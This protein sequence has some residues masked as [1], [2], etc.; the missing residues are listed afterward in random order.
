MAVGK[1]QQILMK[2]SHITFGTN[3]ASSSRAAAAAS[4]WRSRRPH[5]HSS[6]RGTGPTPPGNRGYRHRQ[7]ESLPPAHARP[8]N[9]S[10]AAQGASPWQL[11]AATTIYTCRLS[12]EAVRRRANGLGACLH[13]GHVGCKQ[14]LQFV[15]KHGR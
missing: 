7:C 15:Y 13:T 11:S 3:P 4:C 2:I 8:A 12:E 9:L 6:Q 1:W 14:T 10:S 5:Q